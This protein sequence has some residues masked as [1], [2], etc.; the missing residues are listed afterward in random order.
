MLSFNT[1]DAATSS[2]PVPTSPGLAHRAAQEVLQKPLSESLQKIRRAQRALTR[3]KRR[4][5][6]RV[7]FR[8]SNGSRNSGAAKRSSRQLRPS[9]TQINTAKPQPNNRRDLKSSYEGGGRCLGSPSKPPPPPPKDNVR[10]NDA[11]DETKKATADER[12]SD[13]EPKAPIELPPKSKARGT[14]Q[15]VEPERQRAAEVEKQKL[16]PAGETKQ[17]EEFA[18]KRRPLQPLQTTSTNP[19]YTVFPKTIPRRKP[20]NVEKKADSPDPEHSESVRRSLIQQRRLSA[21]VPADNQPASNE[22][23]TVQRP[24]PDISGVPPSGEKADTAKEQ[25]K[26]QPRSSERTLDKF[27]RELEEFARSTEAFGKIP[28]STPTTVQTHASV[29]T[30]QEFLPYRQQ[31]REAGLAVTSLEQRAPKKNKPDDSENK[32][33]SDARPKVDEKKPGLSQGVSLGSK[34]S[35]I[36]TVI[37]NPRRDPLVLSTAD[38]SEKQTKRTEETTT[39]AT[40]SNTFEKS[41]EFSATSTP[42]K[43]EAVQRKVIRLR[44]ST[45][46]LAN[47]PLPTTPYSPEP[48]SSMVPIVGTK[49]SQASGTYSRLPSDAGTEEEKLLGS[50]DQEKKSTQ[51]NTSASASGSSKGK[52]AV[53]VVDKPEKSLPSLPVARVPS[54]LRH[55]IALPSKTSWVPTTQ[56]QLPTTIVE[57]KEPQPEKTEPPNVSNNMNPHSDNHA[58]KI[59]NK[60]LGT[61]QA[62]TVSVKQSISNKIGI[63]LPET[64]KHAVSTP[65]SFEKALDDIMHK[66][67]AMGEER[68]PSTKAPDQQSDKRSSRGKR[69]SLTKAPSPSQRLQRAAAIRQQRIAEARDRDRQRIASQAPLAPPPLL[70]KM[71][72]PSSSSSSLL[73]HPPPLPMPPRLRQGP[74]PPPP[75]QRG[76]SQLPPSEDDR[77]ISDRDVLKGL[78]IICAASADADFDKMIQ[79]Q[80]GL[81]LRRFLADLRTFEHLN[82]EMVLGGA[83]GRGSGVAGLRMSQARRRVGGG[84]GGVMMGEAG[85]RRMHVQ[86]ERESR[87]RSLRMGSGIGNA[88]GR[89]S[90]PGNGNG[91]GNGMGATGGGAVAGGPMMGG[92]G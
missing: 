7:S 34:E 82:E 80:T 76:R 39:E 25:P 68:Q 91:N 12:H 44:P 46:F 2:S 72:A 30:V 53:R 49:Q 37:H 59:E 28:V 78:K 45:V 69:L 38:E 26:G 19:R 75:L 36:A 77:D 16:T 85:R 5:K 89:G 71:V 67:D 8:H 15:Q 23:D 3:R 17:T 74:P 6:A 29:R 63:L 11:R 4:S 13:P 41:S 57:E 92:M 31:F 14:K 86:A 9:D 66:L 35:S 61:K 20:S 54:H 22:T 47:K 43:L 65:S 83:G 24:L 64:W 42:P 52:E 62:T 55:G 48:P 88:M 87:R 1:P 79:S 40:F 27:A 56:R 81:R 90:G 58:L 33:T 70:G 18:V 21:L 32:T 73:Q 50:V 84:V 10:K 51:P 60:P